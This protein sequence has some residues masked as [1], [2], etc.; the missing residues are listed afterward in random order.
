MVFWFITV[1]FSSLTKY[2]G[3]LGNLCLKGFFRSATPLGVGFANEGF[4]FSAPGHLVVGG[5]LG[6][7]LSE[8][9]QSGRQRTLSQGPCTPAS[10]KN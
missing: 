3:I 6:G 9:G 4:S 2:V 1:F 5:G 10:M 8:P 7:S